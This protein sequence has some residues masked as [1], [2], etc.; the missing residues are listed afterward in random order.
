MNTR[1]PFDA[2]RALRLAAETFDIEAQALLGLKARQG[3]ELRARGARRCSTAA[4]AWS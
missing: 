3:D 2:A 1:N 4:A